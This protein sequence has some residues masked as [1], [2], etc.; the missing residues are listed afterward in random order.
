MQISRAPLKVPLAA[1]PFLKWAGGKTQILSELASH[2][3]RFQRYFEPFVGG[4]AFFFYLASHVPDFEARLSDINADLMNAYRAVKNNVDS[5]AVRLRHHEIAYSRAPVSFYYTLRR[6]TPSDKLDRAAR[7]IA[8]NKTCYNG[9][10]RVNRAGEF[11]VPIGRYKNPA[12]CNELQLGRASEVL[13]RTKAIIRSATYQSS[14]SDAV[15]GDFIYLDPPFVPLSKTANFV[16]YTQAGFS[17]ED[18]VELSEV[19]TKL[20]GKGCKVLLSN[21]DTPLTRKLYS[22]Y[23]QFAVSAS[24]AINCKGD[25]RTGCTELIVRNYSP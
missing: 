18:Q 19:F 14:L 10:Y 3:P 25:G 6:A 23:E 9:L 11:N 1:S 2:V 16:D 17:I 5:L 20:D 24:R 15:R 7:F 13:K 4:G 12:I 21:S 22:S 8:L